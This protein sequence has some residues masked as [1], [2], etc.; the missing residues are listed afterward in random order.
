MFEGETVRLEDDKK[1]AGGTA[2]LV[3]TEHKGERHPRITIV[4]DDGNALWLVDP[5]GQL[6]ARHLVTVYRGGDDVQVPGQ[7]RQL[8]PGLSS[9]LLETDSVT[10]DLLPGERGLIEGG[11]ELLQRAVGPLQND[12][13]RVGLRA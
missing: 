1:G 11:R 8:L 5:H 13:R 10:L 6:G 12:R 2:K 9:D 4:G 3:V 7:L